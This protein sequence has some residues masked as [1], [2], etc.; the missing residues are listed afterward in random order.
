MADSVNCGSGDG[1]KIMERE[2]PM[3]IVDAFSGEPFTGNPA[4]VCLIADEVRTSITLAAKL[5]QKY[6]SRDKLTYTLCCSVKLIAKIKS[7]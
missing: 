4:A 3:F 2:L 1:R 6:P 7:C 5:S